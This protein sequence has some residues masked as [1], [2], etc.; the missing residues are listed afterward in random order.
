M[1]LNSCLWIVSANESCCLCK[2]VSI[3]TMFQTLRRNVKTSNKKNGDNASKIERNKGSWKKRGLARLCEMERFGGCPR[4]WRHDK[5]GLTGCQLEQD[6][7][8]E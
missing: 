4:L 8:H 1:M 2:K 5:V 7:I 3:E 6:I